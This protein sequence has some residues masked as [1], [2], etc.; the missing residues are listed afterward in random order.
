MPARD[1]LTQAQ[2]DQLERIAAVYG[3]TPERLV[4][5][6]TERQERDRNAAR[7][8]VARPAVVRKR[9]AVPFHIGESAGGF[10]RP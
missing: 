5:L 2:R 8:E 1:E 9:P 10:R 3:I 4:A 6:T 7:A